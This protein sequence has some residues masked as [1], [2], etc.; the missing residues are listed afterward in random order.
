MNTVQVMMNEIIDLQNKI[1]QMQESCQHINKVC[2]GDYQDGQPLDED[3]IFSDP[4]ANDSFIA[5]K[6]GTIIECHCP[7]CLKQWVEI[8]L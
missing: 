2:E 5:K 7:E 3:D 4:F 6:T 1:E 8:K